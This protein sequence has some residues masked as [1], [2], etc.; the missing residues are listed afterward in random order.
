M[1]RSPFILLC[2][3]LIQN[4]P[5]AIPTK[6]RY[7]WPSGFRGEDLRQSTNQKKE[8]PMVAMFVNGLELNE[9]SLQMTSNRCILPSFG[10]FGQTVSEGKN[11]KSQP[12]RNKNCLWRPCLLRDRNEMSNHNRG[13]SID[14]SYQ[15]LVHLAK[16]F[17][18]EEFLEINQSETIIACGG[19][20]Y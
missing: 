7:I 1:C 17:R 5:Q 12:I 10:T 18:G 14:D 9:Q 20:V 11:L 6:F 13:L 15:V 19:H 16:R 3:N 2:G 4:L 8:W